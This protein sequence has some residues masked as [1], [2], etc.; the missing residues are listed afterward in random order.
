MFKVW[1]IEELAEDAFIKAEN[2]KALEMMN[3]PVDF[4]KRKEAFVA[5]ALARAAARE[6]ETRL[7]EVINKKNEPVSNEAEPRPQ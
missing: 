3:T 2:V 1:T 7:T 5:L 4:M 6:A